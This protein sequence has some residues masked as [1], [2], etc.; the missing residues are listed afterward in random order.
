MEVDAVE[1]REDYRI[2]VRFEDG[3][4]GEVDLSHLAGKGVFEAWSDRTFF[5]SI[6]VI[7][8]VVSWKG[9]IDLDPCQL[10]MDV[11]GKAIEEIWPG[12]RPGYQDA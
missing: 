2:W 10:Y 12:L 3:V 9:G 8:G 11:T 5:E 6:N 1:P 7:H 4:C